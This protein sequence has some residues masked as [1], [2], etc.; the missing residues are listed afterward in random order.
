M[1]FGLTVGY[2]SNLNPLPNTLLHRP[3]TC[4]ALRLVQCR[5]VLA[6]VPAPSAAQLRR[7]RSYGDQQ[8][9]RIVN[10]TYKTTRFTTTS[11]R[12][13]PGNLPAL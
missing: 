6:G 3:D 7:H 11:S 1:T 12:D 8:V 2:T 10:P 5:F 4:T 13:F 9:G